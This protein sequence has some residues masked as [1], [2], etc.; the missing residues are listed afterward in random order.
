MPRAVS[1]SPLPL[2]PGRYE[3]RLQLGEQS[4]HESFTVR[5]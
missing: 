4:V 5:R 2:A 3:W 1:F